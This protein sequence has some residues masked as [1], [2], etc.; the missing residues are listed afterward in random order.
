MMKQFLKGKKTYIV[1]ALALV[2]AG[3]LFYVGQP[4]AAMTLLAVSG[5]GATLGAKGNRLALDVGKMLE[6]A[7]EK[8]RGGGA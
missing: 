6:A 3:A 2:G 7:G 5:V 1:A 4:D 8:K